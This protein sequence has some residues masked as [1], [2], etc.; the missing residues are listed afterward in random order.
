M[1]GAGA[2]RGRRRT[3]KQ[4]IADGEEELLAWLRQPPTTFEMREKGC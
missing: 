4:I 2:D 1:V 3:V